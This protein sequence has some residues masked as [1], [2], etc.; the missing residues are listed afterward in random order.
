MADQMPSM[1]FAAVFGVPLLRLRRPFDLE[2][3]RGLSVGSRHQQAA[4]VVAES[5]TFELTTTS[6]FHCCARPSIVARAR[7]CWIRRAVPG[8]GR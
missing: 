3:E 1:A 5:G 6:P 2:H 7:T 8:W 4:V